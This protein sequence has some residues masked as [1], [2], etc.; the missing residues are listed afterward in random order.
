M[1]DIV[2]RLS[3]F[4]SIGNVYCVLSTEYSVLRSL[5]QSRI[6]YQF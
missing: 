1:L 3:S 5:I 2:S 6:Q 4:V